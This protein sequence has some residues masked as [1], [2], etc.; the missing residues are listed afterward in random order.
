MNIIAII[1]KIS[2]TK[3]HHLDEDTSD[4]WLELLGI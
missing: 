4:S 2:Q 3:P 1:W